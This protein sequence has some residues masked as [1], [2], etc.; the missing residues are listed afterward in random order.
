[1][2]EPGSERYLGRLCE[3]NQCPKGKMDCLAPGCGAIPFN[4]VIQ[5]FVPGADLLA[6]VQHA[7]LYERG[8]GKLRSALDLPEPE[9]D[10]AP[11]DRRRER[12]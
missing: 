2:I 7:M 12:H 8:R 1:L 10:R 3:F 4:K 9:A 11:A 5:D 6:P